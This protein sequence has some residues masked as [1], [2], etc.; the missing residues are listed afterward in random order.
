MHQ[1]TAIQQ[2]E[3]E[4]LTIQEIT[5]LAE[6]K[7]IVNQGIHSF[8][9]VGS[10]L[11]LIKDQRLYRGTHETFEQFVKEKWDFGRAYAYRLIGSAETMA[12]LSP[13]GDILPA[14]ESHVRALL[15]FSVEDRPKVWK[16][17]VKRLPTSDGKP[18]ISAKEIEHAIDMQVEF[19]TEN[20]P[21]KKRRSVVSGYKSNS[22]NWLQQRVSEFGTREQ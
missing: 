13:I 2:T 20:D 14:N 4:A 11:K 9:E 3:Q 18:V 7:S 5:L 10:A 16:T 6:C 19:S 17:V 8:V 21:F 15:Q 1:S 22:D 12:T